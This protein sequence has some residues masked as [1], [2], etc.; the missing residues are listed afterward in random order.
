MVLWR[1]LFKGTLAAFLCTFFDIFNLEIYAPL[2]IFYFFCI[3]V[4]LCRVKIEH[5]IRYQYVPWNFGKSSYSK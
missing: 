3:M 5:M 2:L 4:L 1:H